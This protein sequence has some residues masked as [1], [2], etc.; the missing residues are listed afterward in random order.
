MPVMDREAV[1]AGAAG[2]AK[3]KKTKVRGRLPSKRSINLATV[4]IKKV[5]WL[6]AIPGTLVLLALAFAFGKFL[7]YDRLQ[8]VYDAQQEA[9]L[10]QR[11]I[12]AGYAALRDYGEL[13]EVYAHYTYS[14]FT[15]EE[16]GRVSRVAAI[17]LLERVV[18]PRTAVRA[19]TLSGNVLTLNIEGSTLQEINETI[20]KLLA[21]DMV[22]YC[23][24][25]TAVT[26]AP[27]DRASAAIAAAV[28]A[29][30]D[31]EA[32][33]ETVTASIEIYLVKEDGA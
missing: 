20:Q 3:R 23:N 2:A 12:D 31:L 10:V 21:E 15:D 28:A 27:E 6:M 17:E 7:V 9:A 4:G 14:N 29:A 33:P 11:Q 30:E 26:I 16:R 18:L 24:V 8:T 1:S 13:N 22:D 5:N 25:N 19:W 32:K